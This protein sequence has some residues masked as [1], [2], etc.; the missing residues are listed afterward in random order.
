MSSSRPV[1][2]LNAANSDAMASTVDPLGF[3]S[4]VG[5]AS[6]TVTSATSSVVDDRFPSGDATVD[7]MLVGSPDPWITDDVRKEILV[8]NNYIL[9]SSQKKISHD[10]SL[11]PSLK[12]AAAYQFMEEVEEMKTAQAMI[13]AME[14]MKE[15]CFAEWE[16]TTSKPVPNGGAT[17]TTTTTRRLKLHRTTNPDVGLHLRT[18][19]CR[20]GS[21]H[22][23]V[24]PSTT[25]GRKR[26]RTPVGARSC[27]PS[28]CERT[29]VTN[30]RCRSPSLRD[31]SEKCSKRRKG[32]IVPAVE[33]QF[34][35][36]LTESRTLPSSS[37]TIKG[38]G[39]H[40]PPQ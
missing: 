26:C 3:P 1:S 11:T 28:L 15:N 9:Q 14:D 8:S 37:S 24:Q 36:S 5:V 13:L 20:T 12:M 39:G 17:S 10:D 2:P 18:C 22:C 40:N 34:L 7:R 16:T 27:V 21:D 6:S 31:V 38:N 32:D 29:S 25:R 33:E 19:L 23:S 35:A 4:G 30:I